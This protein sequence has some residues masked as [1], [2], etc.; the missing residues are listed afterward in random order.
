MEKIKIFDT[1]LRD[2]EQ[3]PG[4]SMSLEEKIEVAKKLESLGVDII[5]AGFAASSPKDKEAIRKISIAIKK[6]VITSLARLVKKDIDEAYEAL[7]MA[8][9]KRIHVF[10]AT[11]DIHMQY[12]LHMTQDDV[13]ANV[14]R[15]VSYAKSLVDDVEFSAE[16][17][18]RS[19]I[20][21]ITK[22]IQTAID[23][24]ATTINLPDTVGYMVPF[25]YMNFINQIKKGLNIPD[26]VILSCHCHNDL[27]MAVANSLAAVKMGIMQVECTINGI[28][29]RAGNVS[30]EQI[31][32]AL[33]T[34]SD[35]FEKTTNINRKEIYSTCNF[36][37]QIIKMPISFNQ[38]IIGQNAFK[39][40][41][42]I[43]QHGIINNAKTY[44]IMQAS[45]YGIP[46]DPLV[47]GIHS[48]HHAIISKIK[49][50]DLNPEDYDIENILKEVKKE[51]I[52]QIKID[53]EKFREIINKYFILKKIKRK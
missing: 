1:T 12:K 21:F 28:G 52:S 40:E 32:A 36:I 24:G 20:S 29:E 49:S 16:D 19:D 10:I 50:L 22:V 51:S 3:S 34:R 5:E 31:V 42:G 8:Q 25:E 4:C 11:S 41:A 2:G 35:Y 13:L 6:P 33:A 18:T 43:H 26:N 38:P 46:Y 47:L 23:N 44:E 15:W 48:G 17:A 7:K 53:E 27:G 37:A 30:L 14:A 39:H 45:D 9:K